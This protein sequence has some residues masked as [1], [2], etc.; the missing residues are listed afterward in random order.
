[1]PK[2]WKP[3][4]LGL[5]LLAQG[6]V[7]SGQTPNHWEDLDGLWWVRVEGLSIWAPPEATDKGYGLVLWKLSFVQDRLYVKQYVPS[8]QDPV[9][10]SGRLSDLPF[11]E[12]PVLDLMVESSFLSFKVRGVLHAYEVYRLEEVSDDVIRGAYLAYNPWG[13]PGYGPEYRG[14]LYLERVTE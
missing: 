2:F 12:L 13:A 1:M 9:F 14:R 8:S 3:W 11:K 5:L 6:A 10:F 4:I 7:L